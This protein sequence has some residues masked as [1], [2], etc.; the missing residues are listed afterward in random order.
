VNSVSELPSEYQT[1]PEGFVD[2]DADIGNYANAS[3]ATVA[4]L[5]RSYPFELDARKIPAGVSIP[6]STPILAQNDIEDKYLGTY[7]KPS[8]GP[9]KGKT[10]TSP[11]I[12]KE[13]EYQIVGVARS[14]GQKGV[15]KSFRVTDAQSKN[16]TVTEGEE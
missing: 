15:R 13:G 6:C 10:L 3:V 5:Y 12:L 11:I 8:S 7:V 4:C 16:D 14:N 2:P 9:N 1:A